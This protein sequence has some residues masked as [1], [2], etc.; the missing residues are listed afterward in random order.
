MYVSA[1]SNDYSFTIRKKMLDIF[2]IAM[3]SEL[4]TVQTALYHTVHAALH[5]HAADAAYARE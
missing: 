1:S 2:A 3:F 5:L 4:Y